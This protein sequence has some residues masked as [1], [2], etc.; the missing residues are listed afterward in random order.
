[1]R[2][3]VIFL[4]DGGVMNDNVRRGACFRELIPH[5]LVPRL[6]GEPRAWSEAN[7]PVFDA[8]MDEYTRR[9]YRRPEADYHAFLHEF[10][11]VRWL[12][13]MCDRVGVV[14]PPDDE[15]AALAADAYTWITRRVRSA[16][17]GAADAV[18]TLSDQGHRL[19]TASG[20]TS[21]ELDGY[22]TGMGV[23]DRFT[24]LYG[25]DLISTAKEGIPYYERV[26]ADAAVDPA[27]AL[28]VDDAPIALSWAAAA[29]A[30]TVWVRGG[31]DEA[32][33]VHLTIERLADLPAALDRLD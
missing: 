30:R 25:P 19:Y 8:L 1:M 15:C 20:E 23:R 32:A 21:L 26:F 22:L 28:V 3:P 7:V 31:R 14:S 11:R 9:L 4:D 13:D 17:P 12:R 10:F 27:D 5:F 24:T 29:G 6:G 16:F 18:R 33:A 2:L